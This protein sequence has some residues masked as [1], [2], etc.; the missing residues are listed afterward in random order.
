MIVECY[1]VGQ[2][3][4]GLGA[5]TAVVSTAAVNAVLA[6]NESRFGHS[7]SPLRDVAR[8]AA[9]E[10]HTL[11]AI[12]AASAT[13]VP[14]DLKDLLHGVFAHADPDEVAERSPG[15]FHDGALSLTR[16]RMRQAQFVLDEALAE[17]PPG[18][19]VPPTVAKARIEAAKAERAFAELLVELL[20]TA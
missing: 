12:H 18:F 10:I 4:R 20:R 14:E 3:G 7:P 11:E 8:D 16:G 1:D 13:S 19:G 2:P 17:S 15:W 5:L 9:V 6:D